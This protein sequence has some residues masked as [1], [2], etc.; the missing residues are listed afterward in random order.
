MLKL[1]Q[2]QEQEQEQQ[3]QQ[4]AKA[5]R[6]LD[7]PEM[8][9]QPLINRFFTT[10]ATQ[11]LATVVRQ[12]A[13]SC[14]TLLEFGCRGGISGLLFLQS[15]LDSQAA[16]RARYVGVDLVEDDSVRNLRSLAE[17]N[18]L[19]FEFWRGHTKA[20]P[21]HET[22]GLCWDTF[23]CGGS[24]FEDL[25]R[26]APFVKKRIFVLG[27]Q[28]HALESEATLRKLDIVQV[29]RELQITA[30]GVQMGLKE[31]LRRFLATHPDWRMER[32]IGEITILTRVTAAAAAAPP[33]ISTSLFTT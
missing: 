2:E 12:H 7:G 11:E 9:L 26:V 25:V 17:Q 23:H 21:L 1:D 24:L 31:G 19:S 28:T 15:L 3:P 6:R 29:A 5:E 14:E 33:A 16:W 13:K 30:D 27:T 8:D 10:P 20:Y 32:E 18:G 22:D 4:R